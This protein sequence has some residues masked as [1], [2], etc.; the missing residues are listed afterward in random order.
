VVSVPQVS[1]VCTSPL[2]HTCHM[3][4]PLKIELLYKNNLSQTGLQLKLKKL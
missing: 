1:P 4:C 3:S 2:P